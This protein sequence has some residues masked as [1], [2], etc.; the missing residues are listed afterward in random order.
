MC[1][2]A[3]PISDVGINLG[4]FNL[5]FSP[6]RGYI[7]I[8]LVCPSGISGLFGTFIEIRRSSVTSIP[9]FHF[10]IYNPV[11]LHSILLYSRC[12]IYQRTLHCAL[13]IYASSDICPTGTIYI[14]LSQP[15][16]T[17]KYAPSACTS[18]TGLGQ[19]K[20]YDWSPVS[21]WGIGGNLLSRNPADKAN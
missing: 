19:D 3:S 4:C 10:S 1:C 20:G 8:L 13:P 6:G 7:H 11:S 18:F 21:C 5:I 9:G 12:I 2:R 15:K 16:L 14:A 17:L